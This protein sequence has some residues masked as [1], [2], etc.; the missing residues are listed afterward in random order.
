MISGN[1]QVVN[2]YAKNRLEVLI[3]MCIRQIVVL[4]WFDLDPKLDKS[5]IFSD[6]NSVHVEPK[7]TTI[8]VMMIFSVYFRSPSENALKF[9]SDLS[10]FE[11]IGPHLE[12]NQTSLVFYWLKI[13][14]VRY[15]FKLHFSTCI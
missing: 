2:K 12:P 11:P 15:I 13:G 3:N 7:C 14:E 10:H 8:L 9:V 4:R 5:G 1:Q 6:Q